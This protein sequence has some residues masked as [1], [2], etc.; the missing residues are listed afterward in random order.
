MQTIPASP[1]HR[2]PRDPVR[3]FNLPTKNYAA[4]VPSETATG[5]SCDLA[6]D[7]A[8]KRATSSHGGLRCPSGATAT[9]LPC[10]TCNTN[11]KRMPLGLRGQ[12]PAPRTAAG[13]ARGLFQGEEGSADPEL[14]HTLPPR[15]NAKGRCHA[16]GAAGHGRCPSQT[17][18]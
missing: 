7:R 12:R 17:W 5:L 2:L 14:S 9:P 1:G 8:C 18:D 3:P 16:G 6:S 4:T 13:P 11:D 15:A 10:T